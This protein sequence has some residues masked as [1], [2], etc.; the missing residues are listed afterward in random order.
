MRANETSYLHR[1]VTG[2]NLPGEVVGVAGGKVRYELGLFMD[3]ESSVR[4]QKSQDLPSSHLSW[5]E[6]NPDLTFSP[7]ERE[8]S[9]AVGMVGSVL[10]SSSKK[11]PWQATDLVLRCSFRPKNYSPSQAPLVTAVSNHDNVVSSSVSIT[12]L[13]RRSDPT[14]LAQIHFSSLLLTHTISSNFDILFGFISGDILL[15]NLPTGSF[16]LRV[17]SPPTREKVKRSSPGEECGVSSLLWLPGYTTFLSGHLSGAVYKHCTANQTVEALKYDEDEKLPSVKKN[18]P[19]CNPVLCLRLSTQAILHMSIPQ[20]GSAVNDKIAAAGRD[21]HCYIVDTSRFKVVA[22]L[23]TRFGAATCCSW[24]PCGRFLAVG[25]QD[26]TVAFYSSVGFARLAYLVG[27]QNWVSDVF[28]STIRASDGG[29][30]VT[31]ACLD[32]RLY[33]WDVD[34]KGLAGELEASPTLSPTQVQLSD[35]ASS[36]PSEGDGGTSVTP[37]P[38]WKTRYAVP[39]VDADVV[40][41]R[42]HA[43]APLLG[44]AFLPNSAIATTCSNGILQIWSPKKTPDPDLTPHNGHAEPPQ[45]RHI[46]SRPSASSIPPR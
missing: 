17:T 32:G 29:V 45:R 15:Y 40:L 1:R 39:E 21:G 12:Q 5:A 43:G 2:F 31:S 44:A 16:T 24:T 13:D 8:A 6:G 28:A 36:V 23:A 9:S 35:A 10:Y 42:L 4:R 20:S 7:S 3:D 14:S 30:T 33:L 27:P 38:T 11:R 25:A 19:G 34:A 46:A 18:K 41:E 37:A 22:K 26:D